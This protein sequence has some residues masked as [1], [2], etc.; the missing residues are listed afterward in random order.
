[1]KDKVF[2]LIAINMKKNYKDK[3]RKDLKITK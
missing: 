1:M 3:Q 2:K